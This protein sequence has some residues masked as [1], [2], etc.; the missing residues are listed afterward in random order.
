[1]QYNW[2]HFT[3]ETSKRVKL[4]R[5]R[6][7]LKCLWRNVPELLPKKIENTTLIWTI[8]IFTDALAYDQRLNTLKIL[9]HICEILR[10]CG[11]NKTCLWQLMEGCSYLGAGS[12]PT[13]VATQCMLPVQYW[14]LTGPNP[15]RGPGGLSPT[16]R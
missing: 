14:L 8:Y 11:Y 1:M 13:M 6:E 10:M 3:C 15:G 9:C 16:P 12:S 7:F 4:K 5:S 2:I